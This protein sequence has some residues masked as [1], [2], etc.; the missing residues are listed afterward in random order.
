MGVVVTIANQKGG[1]GKTITASCT[2]AILTE[3]GYKVLIISLDPQRNLDMVAGDGLAIKRND[4]TTL[5]MLQVMK[6]TCSLKEAI[7]PSVLGDIARASSQLYQW[8]GEQTISMDEYMEVRDNLEALQTLLDARVQNEDS[9]MKVLDAVLGPVKK[10]YDY[11]L[12]DTNPSLTLLTLN[13]L[14]AADYI[15]I[16]AFSEE[17]SAEAI[18]ELWD[19]VKT[20]KYYNPGKHLEIL[21]ILMTRCN[22]RAIA[23]QRHI[24]KY[25]M[26]AQKIGIRLFETKIR[27]SARAGDYV[28]SGV[29]LIHYDPR[30]KT[31]DDYRNFVE[32][33]KQVITEEEA[34]R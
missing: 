21:G 33:L 7:V 4:H 24:N 13:S 18:V 8:T 23:F 34:A 15:V 14:F 11:I 12:I 32:E 17:T 6:G 1:V 25:K 31:T 22:P 27:Q 9:N 19:T 10:D 5:S 28:E 20:I 29:D 2:A 26:M 30:G 3:Q 16:P